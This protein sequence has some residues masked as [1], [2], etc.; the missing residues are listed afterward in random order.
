M[1]SDIIKGRFV[2]KCVQLLTKD[3]HW[4]VRTQS[5]HLVLADHSIAPRPVSGD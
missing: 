1:E 3:G 5:E 2:G 4:S